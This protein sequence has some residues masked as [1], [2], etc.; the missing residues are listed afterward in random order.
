M[1]PHFRAVA[2]LI[3]VIEGEQTEDGKKERND[4]LIAVSNASHTHS[5][6][7]SVDDL[8]RSLLREVEKFFINYHAND[9]AEFKVLACKGPQAAAKCLKKTQLKAA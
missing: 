1:N 2:R 3:G 6:I 8:N 5:D 4:R 7:R 9:G